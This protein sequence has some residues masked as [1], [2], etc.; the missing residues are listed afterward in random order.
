MDNGEHTIKSKGKLKS[1]L[2]VI[3]TAVVAIVV[4]TLVQNYVILP[5]V[6]P[7]GSME[8]TI[9]TDDRIYAEKLSYTFGTVQPG[10][11]V[12]FQDPEMPSR[13]LLKR[14][15]ATEGQVID[16][17]D[18]KLYIDGIEQDEPYVGEEKTKPLENLNNPITYPYTVPQ[19]CVWYMG[20]N[21]D[22]SKDSRFFGAVPENTAI[23]KA[24][25]RYWPITSMGPVG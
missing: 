19:G 10:D 21:R 1:A 8:E 13:D 24:I 7:S 2:S 14:A 5:Y 6:I 16:I 25:F 9:M 4:V 17:K 15:I 20:D 22:N 23:A 12:I 18:D 3:A 11:I